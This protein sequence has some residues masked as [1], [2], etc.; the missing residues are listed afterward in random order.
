MPMFYRSFVVFLI[1]GLL[2]ICRHLNK[3]VS[4]VD[5]VVD[6][7]CLEC[8]SLN[9]AYVAVSGGDV[10]PYLKQGFAENGHESQIR[11][12][13]TAIRSKVE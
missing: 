1:Y 12:Y 13:K 2:L 9:L 4:W 3:F 11:V 10:R 6:Y 8:K 5:I 7:I